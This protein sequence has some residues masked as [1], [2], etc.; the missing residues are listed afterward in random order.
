MEMEVVDE[1]DVGGD[2]PEEIEGASKK[3]KKS[4]KENKD[5]GEG[6]ITLF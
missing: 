2:K 5:S 6:Q 1:E 4:T 3:K